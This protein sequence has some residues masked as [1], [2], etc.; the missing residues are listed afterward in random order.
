ML[1]VAS[2]GCL[3]NLKTA[4]WPIKF[5]GWISPSRLACEAFLRAMTHQIPDYKFGNIYVSRYD[6]LEERGF[7]YG[8]PK[9]IMLLVVWIIVW[10][11]MTLIVVNIKLR[12]L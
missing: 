11:I 9:C 8:L 1:F 6:I 5:L 10:I 2:N 12:K 4:M 7:E 3:V